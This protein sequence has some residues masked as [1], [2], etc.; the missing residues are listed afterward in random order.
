M[1]AIF[2]HDYP[3]IKKSVR[4]LFY[5]LDNFNFLLK[6]NNLIFKVD[7]LGKLKF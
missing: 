3:F 5:A 4:S 2:I 1:K 6:E 7:V